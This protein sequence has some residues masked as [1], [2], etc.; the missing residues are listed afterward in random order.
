MYSGYSDSSKSYVPHFT[1]GKEI[2]GINL[3][4]R[5]AGEFTIQGHGVYHPAVS[6]CRGRKAR[7]RFDMLWE[8]VCLT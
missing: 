6:S 1:N 2:L 7:Q 5:G 3:H 8:A 4:G